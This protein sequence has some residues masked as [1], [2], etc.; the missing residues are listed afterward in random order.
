MKA[1]GGA[2]AKGGADAKT[3]RR[4]S[5][6]T[7]RA[8]ARP[9][10]RDVAAA[11]GVSI[12]TASNAFNRP[13]LISDALR[14][15]VLGEA[16]RI[17]YAGP[18]PAARRLRTGRAGAFGLV[19]TDRLPFAFDD[20]AAVVF[21]RG[22]A[23]ALEDSG[24]GLLLIPT[25]PTREAGAKVVRAAAV[26]GFI[27]YSTPTGDPRL[28]AALE[29]GLPTITVDQPVDVPT[30]F[31]GIDD[32]AAAR[33]AAL[34]VRQLGHERVAVI[35]FPEFARDDGT[36]PFDVTRERL[37]GYR[38]G[39]GEAWS[40]DLLA[41]ATSS[42]PGSARELAGELLALERPPTAVLAMSDA[43]AAGVVRAAAE[44]GLTVPADLSVVGFDDVPLARLRDPPLTTVSQ[45]SERK[46]ELAA[47]A[48]L[49]ALDPDAQP[50][51]R[52]TILPTELVVRGTT[53]APPP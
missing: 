9:T 33:A 18:D 29:R 43:L 19:F 1:D 50:Q 51:P 45:P 21:L 3:G 35:G 14:E 30:P 11:A 36:L 27:V 40:D 42:R 47:R 7:G 20:E 22:V 46:G 37:A 17:G 23:N 44:R 24:A 8:A 32:R 41:T 2:G 52:A 26:D 5:R 13:E 49:A 53:A 25:S 15:R 34:H 48:L 16:R 4:A 28:E 10:L 12:G 38:E 31:I 6:A 39:L